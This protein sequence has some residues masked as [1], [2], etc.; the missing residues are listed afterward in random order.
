MGMGRQKRYIVISI[1]LINRAE[2]HKV[3]MAARFPNCITVDE[4]VYLHISITKDCIFN[5]NGIK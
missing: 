2:E 5:K 1:V 4:S 3:K